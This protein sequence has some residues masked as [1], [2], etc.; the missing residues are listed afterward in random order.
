MSAEETRLGRYVIESEL[1]RG[2]MGV[3]FRARDPR[4]DRL[5]ALKTLVPDVA[6]EEIVRALKD[7][8]LN[9]GRAAGRLSHPGVV[10]VYD[11]DEDPATGTAYL[12]MEF[13]DG[14][15]LRR[16]LRDGLPPARL[17]EIVSEVA[18]ALDHAHQRGVVHRDVK[19]GNI[20]VDAMGRARLTDFGIAR[21]GS[22][23]MT[24]A[25]EFLG[26]PA[27]MAPEQIMGGQVGPATDIFALGVV[28]YEGLTGK[29]PFDGDSMVATTHAIV[30][31]EPPPPSQARA[32]ISPAF[33]AVL[34]KALAKAPQDRY[35][36]AGALGEG[37]AA[38]LRATAG[39][40]ST[41]LGPQRSPITTAPMGAM[42][43]AAAAAP[44]RRRKGLLL[45]LAALLVL[46]PGAF[47]VSKVA[48]GPE[49][50]EPAP[51]TT[52]PVAAKSPASKPSPRPAKPSRSA[53]TRSAPSGKLSVKLSTMRAGT[54]TVSSDGKVLGQ[55]VVAANEDNG[56]KA[57][58]NVMRERS[59]TLTAPTG[60]HVLRFVFTNRDG[61]TIT[62]D[63]ER[64]LPEGESLAATVDI[65]F[66]GKDFSVDFE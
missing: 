36:S 9:E 25:G 23:T 4:I 32:S 24:R 65:G 56:P 15:D 39:L 37:A 27:Y 35:P 40:E 50:A 13:V 1:G 3:V 59:A 10:A 8:F 7:R 18:A 16:L 2:A 60:R 64:D 19:P 58:G 45:A 6:D 43:S 34:A 29:R 44:S 52:A 28:L 42:S 46:A 49:S 5:V 57:L 61:S 22:S 12:A 11:A 48:R 21:L 54:L 53:P 63:Y 66:R 62:K 47:I 14:P 30:S 55:L 31:T 41:M 38:A 51:T 17:V 33:D 20:L 26:T